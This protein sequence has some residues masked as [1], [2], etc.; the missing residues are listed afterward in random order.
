M[1]N[2]KL[3][4]SCINDDFSHIKDEYSLNLILQ[5]LEMGVME[6]LPG[7]LGILHFIQTDRHKSFAVFPIDYGL[8]C[9]TQ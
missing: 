2:Y 7:V 8:V 4:F 9:G 5:V 6:L 1:I 3:S